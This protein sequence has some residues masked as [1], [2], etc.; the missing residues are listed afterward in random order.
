MLS[1]FDEKVKKQLDLLT[2]V[3]LPNNPEPEKVLR[4]RVPCEKLGPGN[5][6]QLRTW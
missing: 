5:L 2:G 4:K 1:F 3:T 6:P